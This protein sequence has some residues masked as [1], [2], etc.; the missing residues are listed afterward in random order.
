M[1]DFS[2]T[3]L[4]GLDAAS[5]ELSM[6][7]NNIANVNTLGYKSEDASFYELYSGTSSG[8]IGSG[9]LPGEVQ[10]KFGQGNTIQTGTSTDMRIDGGGFFTL[11]DPGA[12]QTYYSRAGAFS[13]DDSGYLQNAQGYRVQGYLG[14]STSGSLS[15]LQ[16]SQTPLAPSATANVT[17]T[18][19]LVNA[20]SSAVTNTVTYYDTKGSSHTLG[21]TFT[22]NSGTSKWDL[23]YTVDS[24]AAAQVPAQTLTFSTAGAVSAGGTQTVDLGGG[25]SLALD[26][27]AMTS[28]GSGSNISGPNGTADG[29]PAGNYSGFTLQKGGILVENYTNGQTKQVG[30]LALTSFFA[31]NG[32]LNA[33]NSNWL[34]GPNVGTITTGVSGSADLG[35]VMSGQLEGSNVDLSSQVVDMISAQRDFQ[36]DAQVLKTGKML[37]QTVLS[38]NN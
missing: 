27:S 32:L 18:G 25:N 22:Y 34:A 2:N 36:S 31:K 38:I 16:V 10:Y 8:G 11:R 4:S 6:D 21:V 9:A 29:Y 3:A 35:S 20:S 19:N 23:T 24:T 7:S 26:L 28:Y 15:D 13:L 1:G 37:D 33:G 5:F 17:F 12:G 30:S 14:T